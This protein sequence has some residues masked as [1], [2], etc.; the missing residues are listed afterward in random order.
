MKKL[1]RAVPPS[2]DVDTRGIQSTL[3]ASKFRYRTVD[4][5]PGERNAIAL[6]LVFLLTSDEEDLLPQLLPAWE[7]PMPRNTKDVVAGV[8]CHDG[9]QYVAEVVERE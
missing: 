1:C 9:C 4:L 7:V 3:D 6:A 2:T 8:Q 5:A